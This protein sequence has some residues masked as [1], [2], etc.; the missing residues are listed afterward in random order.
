MSKKTLQQIAMLGTKRNRINEARLL[1]NLGIQELQ[2]RAGYLPKETLSPQTAPF[3]RDS[4]E[5][6]SD[7][8]LS[9]L[10]DILE[11]ERPHGLAEWIVLAGEAKQIIPA[12]YLPVLLRLGRD[13]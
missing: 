1:R 13:N 10:R 5:Y 2:G 12:E 6:C 7:I 9:Y 11:G 4:V 3:K 8:A